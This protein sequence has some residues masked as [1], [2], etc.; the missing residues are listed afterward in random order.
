MPK[1]AVY[2]YQTTNGRAPLINWLK[3]QNQRVQDKATELV[4]LLEGRG[5]KL[6]MPHAKVLRSGIWELRVIVQRVQHRILYAFVGKNIVLLTHGLT[7]TDKVPAKEIDKAI[8]YKNEYKQNPKQ[9]TYQ[10]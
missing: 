4:T 2:I 3:G 8:R 7:K 6:S 9:H 10:R 1:T 5:H